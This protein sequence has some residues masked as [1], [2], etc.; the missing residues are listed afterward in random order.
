MNKVCASTRW[1]KLKSFTTALCVLIITH[2]QF[3]ITQ[4]QIAGICDV[5][6]SLRKTLCKVLGRQRWY[7][8][9]PIHGYP[10][11][12]SCYITLQVCILSISNCLISPMVMTFWYI[13]G[14]GQGP[15]Q[16]FD[17]IRS[18]HCTENCWAAGEAR[19]WNVDVPSCIAKM[20]YMCW[21]MHD[22]CLVP[23]WLGDK[24]N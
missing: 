10:Q 22:N 13:D 8:M 7:V 4:Y 17:H 2:I 6:M 21:F 19:D 18:W 3:V 11:P 23:I 1:K 16:H 15:L 20:P 9:M 24:R 5:H 12:T 14:V